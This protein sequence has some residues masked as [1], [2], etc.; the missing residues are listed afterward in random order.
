MES[1]IDASQSVFRVSREISLKPAGVG[2]RRG[3]V[4]PKLS[5][6]PLDTTLRV[7]AKDPANGDFG[8]SAT[9]DGEN[10]TFS[11]RR[12]DVY[13][14]GGPGGTRW[15]FRFTANG[16]PLLTIPLRRYEDSGKPTRCYIRNEEMRTAT[17]SGSNLQPV[18]FTVEGLRRRN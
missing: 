5:P 14:D 3:A 12:I 13:S 17:F 8:F 7:S 11:L 6:S 15:I 10:R 1:P 2:G 9:I 18:N 4:V 16:K